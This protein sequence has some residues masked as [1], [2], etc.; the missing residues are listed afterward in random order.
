MALFQARNP[1][2]DAAADKARLD[3]LIRHIGD[4]RAG[5]LKERRGLERRYADAAGIAADLVDNA[6][7]VQRE[8][9]DE[10]ALSRAERDLMHARRRMAELDRQLGVLDGLSERVRVLF[11]APDDLRKLRRG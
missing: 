5:V 8:A 3:A 7:E 9:E 4:V 2:R 6:Y 11:V 1:D 10:A